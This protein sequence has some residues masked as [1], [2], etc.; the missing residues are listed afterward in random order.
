MKHS[1]KMRALGLALSLLF[2]S[3]SAQ[4]ETQETALYTNENGALP[5]SSES[6]SEGDNL[7]EKP[8]SIMLPSS[9]QMLGQMLETTAESQNIEVEIRLAGN[10]PRYTLEL[11]EAMESDEKP[12]LYWMPG[13]FAARVLDESSYYLYN[14]DVPASGVML[15]SVAAM[16]PADLRL[17]NEEKTFALPV[18]AYAQ[19]TLVQLSLLAELLGTEDLIALQRDL[20]LCSY[21]EWYVMQTAIVDYLETPGRYQF[22][23][24]G[25]LYTMPSY[26]PSQAETL[27][28]LWALATVGNTAYV[29]NGITAAFSAAYT[30]PATYLDSDPELLNDLMQE[31]LEALYEEIEFETMHMVGHDG[32]LARGENFTLAREV[33]EEEAQQFF[34]NGSALLWKCDTRQALQ[35]EEDNPELAGDLFLIPTKLPFE[36]DSVAVINQL[37][38]LEIDGYLAVANAKEANS[39]A[40]ELLVQWFTQEAC[41]QATQTGLHLLPYTAFYPQSAVLRSL[42]E[43]VSIGE[44]YLAPIEPSVLATTQ[45][46]MGDW[47]RLN[48][49]DKSEWTEE[50]RAAFLT[51]VQGMWGEIALE[52]QDSEETE[53]ETE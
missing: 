4:V 33:T 17:L 51:A 29:Q 27:R 53:G 20:I 14:L 32:S 35:I 24:G 37:Y 28:G 50:D 30:D 43:S 44:Y 45:Q 21:E 41:L 31:P 16:V 10:E 34:E 19:G 38:T 18:G 11:L 12:D 15:Q 13:E 42:E 3:C 40:G 25:N 39:A 8:V 2:V 23:L 26:R 9:Q 49:M 36:N 7:E 46:R 22:S 6:G 5:K 1:R 52:P 47:I 48:L